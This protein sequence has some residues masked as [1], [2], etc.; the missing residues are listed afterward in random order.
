[1]KLILKSILFRK[2]EREMIRDRAAGCQ[3]TNKAFVKLLGF[4]IDDS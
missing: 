4:Q 3:T 1:M 2:R